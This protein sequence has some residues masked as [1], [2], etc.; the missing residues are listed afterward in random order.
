[1]CRTFEKS[2]NNAEIFKATKLIPENTISSNM[3][4]I[5][6][7]LGKYYLVLKDNVHV[8]GIYKKKFLRPN[9]LRSAHL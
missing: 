3:Y 8:Q 9:F 4:L 1:M 7:L 6:Y 5:N 2:L